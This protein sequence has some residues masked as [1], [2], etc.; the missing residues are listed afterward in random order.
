[1]SRNPHKE[2]HS[3]DSMGKNSDFMLSSIVL[4][5]KKGGVFIANKA[6]FITTETLALHESVSFSRKNEWPLTVGPI[7]KYSGGN[8]HEKRMI[9]VIQ[10][11][12]PKP[13]NHE[14]MFP[15]GRCNLK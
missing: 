3:I 8:L 12:D 1:M 15:A 4:N 5:V 11:G 9:V 14:S 2:T 6:V 7:P 10:E 13:K